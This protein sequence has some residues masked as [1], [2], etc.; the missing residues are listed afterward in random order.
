MLVNFS[1]KNHPQSRLPKEI[2]VALKEKYFGG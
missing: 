1:F 2:A